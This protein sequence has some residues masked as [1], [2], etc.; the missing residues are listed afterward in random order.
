MNKKLA[1]I[2]IVFL[3]FLWWPVTN[4]EG[5][6]NSSPI[7]QVISYKYT[8]GKYF[9]LMW[10]G[11]A[12]IINNTWYIITNNHV[13]D[14]EKWGTLDYFNICI[15]Q[16][17]WQRP[18]CNYTAVLIARN[19][20]KDIALL[21]IEDIDI[22][23]KKVDLSSLSSISPDYNYT[24]KSWDEVEAIGYPWVGSETIT[25]TQGIISGTSL[26]NDSTYL[27]TDALI[28]SGNSGWAL[29][30]DKKL[31]GIPTFWVGWWI[32]TT[33]WYGLLISDAKEFI[34]TNV[35]IEPKKSDITIFANYKK[36]IEEINKNKK[37]KDNFL[38]LPF[39]DKYEVTDYDKDRFLT[40]KPA[41]WN[42]ELPQSISFS[43]LDLPNAESEKNFLYYLQKVWIYNKDTQKLKKII[44][45]WV[46]FYNPI[47]LYDTSWWDADKTKM[48]F[49]NIEGKIIVIYVD[50][51]TP[52]EDKI[53]TITSE[54]D[55][56][57]KAVMFNK[58]TIKNI[59][60]EF[61]LPAPEI[62]IKNDKNIVY[63]ELF[64]FV[65][66]FPFNNL[67]EMITIN[68][69]PLDVSTGKWKNVS[70]IYEE[71]AK[72]ISPDM[73]SLIK[74]K[75]HEWFVYC[76]DNYYKLDEIQIDELWNPLNQ[77]SCNIKIYWLKWIDNDYVLDINLVV[78]KKNKIAW[79][80]YLLNWLDTLITLPKL[81]DGQNTLVNVYKK[82]VK[83]LFNDIQNQSELYKNKLKLL[84]KYHIL[85]NTSRLNPYKPIKRWE[86]LDF[87]F[88]NVYKII[89]DTKNCQKTDSKCRLKAYKIERGGKKVSLAF[90]LNQLGIHTWDYVNSEKINFL[91]DVLDMIIWAKVNE[92]DITE[93]MVSNYMSLK[94]E[95]PYEEI[96]KKI[97]DWFFNFYGNKKI[98]LYEVSS[99]P[100]FSNFIA[101]KSLYYVSGSGIVEKPYFSSWKLDFSKNVKEID[102]S[103][104]K[105]H[106]PIVTKAEM[107]DFITDFID[108]GLFDAELAKKKNTT[109]EE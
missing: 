82:Q 79:L 74:F 99:N 68:I 49:W 86:F 21:K 13:V 62:K 41:T 7:V 16:S 53:N 23:G 3:S 22:Y 17:E 92:A 104:A 80:E 71:G 39:W 66:L 58:D 65:W 84:V 8:Y 63:N 11:S 85:E 40:I 59:R 55:T 26:Y 45:S 2:F 81:G 72:D 73:K 42:Q 76:T 105:I 43:I 29:I 95:E 14:N 54:F 93:E 56:L 35:K 98:T 94:K 60:F 15:S 47:G 107:I 61:N 89:L 64:W 4:W 102:F 44:I 75:W 106:Y 9:Q 88:S 51:G 103:H 101:N 28:A 1:L 46:E 96:T 78:D 57:L 52:Q 32:D 34:E 31:I 87:Y 12:S 38:E 50:F 33:L 24:P 97:E 18:S 69:T 5:T 108:F 10:W 90:L 100:E 19:E 25:K 36:Q 20:K 37:I 27:K 109:I 30:K 67:H 6:L 91:P 70:S 48:Y 83:L 77:S